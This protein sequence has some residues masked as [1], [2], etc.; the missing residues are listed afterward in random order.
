MMSCREK[1]AF[2]LHHSLHTSLFKV[3]MNCAGGERLIDDVGEGFGDLDSIFCPLSEDEMDGMM[4]IGGGKLLWTTAS[5]LLKLRT[6]F[7]VKYGYSGGM[8][9]S[10]S[11]DRVGGLASIKHGEDFGLLCRREGSHDDGG[12]K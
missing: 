2:G 11:G 7:G 10:S 3:K 1:R 8:D 6:L 9:T 12:R 5:G 4:D